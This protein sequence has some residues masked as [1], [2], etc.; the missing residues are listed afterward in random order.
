LT[1]KRLSTAQ[2][3]IF[4]QPPLCRF[5]NN[6]ILTWSYAS[7]EDGTYYVVVYANGSA[8]DYKQRADW[9]WQF[10][11]ATDAVVDPSFDPGSKSETGGSSGLTS[12]IAICITVVI[13]VTL[14]VIG[15]V[16]L[17]KIYFS[18]SVRLRDRVQIYPNYSN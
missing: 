14:L 6:G 16:I 15:G 17:S 13:V 11:P 18:R 4:L 2:C 5:T 3:L 1:C 9:H 7:D 12:I 8:Q 10:T